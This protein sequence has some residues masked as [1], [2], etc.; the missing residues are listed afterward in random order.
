MAGLGKTTFVAGTILTASQVNGY[1]MDQVV[2]VYAGTAA[3]GSAIGGSTTEGMMTYLADTNSVQM[4]TGTATFVNVD[5]LPIVAGTATRDSLYPVPTAGNTVYRTDVGAQETYFTLY[6]A[7]TNPGGAKTAGWYPLSGQAIF[8]AT[9]SRTTTSGATNYMGESGFAYTEISD[10]YAWHDAVTNPTRVT[11]NKEGIYRVTANAI[12]GSNA[13]NDR[14]MDIQKNGTVIPTNDIARTYL[15]AAL[16]SGILTLTG[17]TY[18]NGSTDW[19][20]AS[21]FQNSGVSLTAAGVFT[22]E[23]IRPAIA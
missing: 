2:Q 17:T 11:P 19:V 12:F 3:R 20:A 4:A 23:F 13:T 1:L 21:C 16:S 15:S 5:S 8:H 10:N 7:S 22:V 14:I 9:C 6:N 18:M